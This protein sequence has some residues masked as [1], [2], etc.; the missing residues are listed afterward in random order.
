[1]ENKHICHLVQFQAFNVIEI[2]PNDKYALEVLQSPLENLRQVQA[3]SK[4]TMEEA[5]RTCMGQRSCKVRKNIKRSRS[6]S[7]HQTKQL[8]FR[9]QTYPMPIGLRSNTVKKCF[10]KLCTSRGQSFVLVL[11]L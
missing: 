9:C 2:E 3:R 7:V 6:R 8:L 10:K 1:M 4:Q 11:D 5:Y